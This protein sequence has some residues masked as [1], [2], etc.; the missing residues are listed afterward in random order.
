MRTYGTMTLKASTWEI[1]A[2]PH[3]AM[4]L[5]RIFKRSDRG[6]P[7]KLRLSHTPETCRDLE[8]VLDRYP[9][10]VQ[11]R[12]ALY[13]A[14]Q[15]HKDMV[16]RLED[17]LSGSYTPRPWAMA[18]PPR[19]YQATEAEIVLAQ[20]HL[21]V[22]DDVGLG[23]T[24]TGA[25]VISDTSTR[26]AVVVTMTH[27]PRQW[28]RELER[29]LPGVFVHVTTKGQ[30]YP[31]PTFLGNLPDVVITTYSKLAG[32]GDVLGKFAR[33]VIFDEIQELRRNES[34]KYAGAEALVEQAPYRVG[35][36]ATPI[37]N[38]GDEMYNVLQLLKPGALGAFDEFRREWCKDRGDKL[39]IANPRAFGS[40]LRE[41]VL[42]VRHTRAEVGREL[43]PVVPIVQTVDTD[44]SKLAE[45]EGSA[46]QLARVI[47]AATETER[48]AKMQA[49]EHLSNL[50]R[51]ATGI[52]KAPY[53]ADFVR[54]LVES[55]ERVVLVGWHREVYSIWQERLRGLRVALYTGTE[56]AA[57][58]DDV[59]WQFAAKE[60]DVLILSLRSGAGLDGL[61]GA[62]NVLVFGELDWSPG[63]HEQVIGRLH[64]DGQDQS[65]LVYY[66]VADE[67][68]DP[69][70]SEVLGL[71][72]DQI[73]GLRDP[74]RPLVELAQTDPDRVKRLAE[75]Y[76]RARKE[77][78]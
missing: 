41:Q 35:L 30:P 38:Y 23:K 78:A 53:V 61:Q 49:S 63:V 29:A 58:K 46:V 72:G 22:A 15:S 27:L 33:C 8:W 69:V 32:W 19:S 39:L 24:W 44:A 43:P 36:S 40:W 18:L 76:L 16:L 1:K 65:V 57:Q 52:A 67:G 34:K 21:L 62:G 51:Q 5:K 68:S 26:P 73:A 7:G 17:Y 75:Q 9:M 56:T 11:P 12:E 71:K 77:A 50:V 60:L 14:S 42:M 6:S 2:D 48:G 47:L 37:Y 4:R 13:S 54:L 20:G 59:A 66:L 31:L 3:V 10:E 64:R 74:G 70:V 55:G 25:A 28:K 45:I